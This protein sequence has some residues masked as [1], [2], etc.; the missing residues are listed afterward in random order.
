MAL[1]TR[2]DPKRIE[3]TAWTF[4]ERC[5]GHEFS[6]LAEASD[7]G[8]VQLS[9]AMTLSR[10]ARHEF[11]VKGSIA[12][13]I[14][15]VCQRCLERYAENV[16]LQFDEIFTVPQPYKQMA[17]NACKESE[18]H[19]SADDYFDKENYF[20]LQQYLEDELLLALPSFPAH[21][22]EKECNP[23]MLDRINDKT[24]VAEEKPNP[25]SVLNQL[26]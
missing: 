16:T 10:E 23:V 12:L 19:S 11:R 6:R 7:S 4:D 13:S 8:Q 26:N 5:D 25:F 17:I 3:S 21:A 22:E 15:L 14:D 2:I 20:C 24:E 18:D 1:P 9:V